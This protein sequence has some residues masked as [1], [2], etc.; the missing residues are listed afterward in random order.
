VIGAE[1]IK[2]FYQSKLLYYR[3]ETYGFNPDGWQIE[4]IVEVMTILLMVALG[5]Q[6]DADEI[7]VKSKDFLK[8]L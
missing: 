8:N 7:F 2:F 6:H 4:S 1:L 3:T 5:K